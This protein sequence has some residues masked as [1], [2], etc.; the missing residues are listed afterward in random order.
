MKQRIQ[1]SFTGSVQGVGFRFHASH[2]AV[3][4][5]LTGWV[6]NEYDGSVT[7][8]VQGEQNALSTVVKIIEQSPYISIDT[9]RSVALPLDPKEKSFKI[10]Y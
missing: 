6:R 5:G 4:L 8:E 9:V 10:R 3:S 2:A 1:Y 7:M